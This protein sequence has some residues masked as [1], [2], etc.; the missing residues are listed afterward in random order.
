MALKNLTVDVLATGL[1]ISPSNPI[2]GLEG[3]S[4][5]LIKLGHAMDNQTFFGVDAR[6]GNMLGTE[7]CC[8][9]KGSP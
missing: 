5:L 7:H 4:S 3:R 8:P 1:Q 2:D 9:L 6:P